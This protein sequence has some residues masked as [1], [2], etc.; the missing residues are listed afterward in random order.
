M[1]GY[2]RALV[3]NE[4]HYG[5]EHPEVAKT[6]GNLGNAYG[7]LGDTARQKA[8]LERALVILER[9]YGPEHPDVAKTLSKL[10]QCLWRFG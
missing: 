3:I 2:E 7:D 4:R 8:L 5:P 6:L 10:R 9:H 1:Y